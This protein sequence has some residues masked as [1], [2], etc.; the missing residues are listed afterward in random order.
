MRRPL[1]GVT[2]YHRDLGA[3]APGGRTRFHL[4]AAYVDAVRATGG[5]ALLLPPGDEDPSQALEA[6]DG[7]VLCGG[8]DIEPERYGGRGHEA[9]YATCG[10][11]DAFEIALV[12]AALA[13]A[14]PLLAICRGLQVLN[15]ALG[16]DLH[17]HLPDVV[18]EE[19]SHRVSR[20]RHSY[21]AV[22][23][24]PASQ[25]AVQLERVELEVASWH[26][27]AIARLGS[28]LRAVAWA[29]DGTVEAVELAGRPEV[30]AVQWHPELHAHE[31]GS[32][33]RRLFEALM[34][35]ARRRPA[36]SGTP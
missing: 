1:I 10:E 16:G 36:R 11:R 13:R 31:P 18:G 30:V 24:E 28:G 32:P 3:H 34:E 9:Q 21:H 12:E 14:T 35:Q 27:Q 2:T 33:H 19:V 25:L 6:L 29:E 20:E 23:I 5:V 26:H 4:P 8:G 15:V 22:R 7:L 17:A